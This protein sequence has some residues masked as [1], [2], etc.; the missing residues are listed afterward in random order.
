MPGQLVK[1]GIPVTEHKNELKTKSQVKSEQ[2][3][4]EGRW[5]P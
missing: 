4:S 2:R 5:L 1:K 3:L